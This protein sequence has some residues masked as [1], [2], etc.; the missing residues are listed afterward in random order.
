M[1][2]Q[3]AH[4]REEEQALQVEI[5]FSTYCEQHP[6][7][8]A[9]V[10]HPTICCR[11]KTWTVILGANLQEGI[12]G[13]GNTLGAAL[14]DFD[15]QYLNLLHPPIEQPQESPGATMLHAP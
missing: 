7:G 15:R 2:K 5:E 8:P 3:H 9:A 12:V 14:A 10:R 11:G 6:G 1:R 4:S 13:L